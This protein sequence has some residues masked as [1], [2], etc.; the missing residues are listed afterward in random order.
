MPNYCV[1][2]GGDFE[3]YNIDFSGLT[4]I[5]DLFPLNPLQH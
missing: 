2:T 5:N 4:G 3:V 1:N